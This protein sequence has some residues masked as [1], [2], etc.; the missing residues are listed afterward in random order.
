MQQVQLR[1]KRRRRAVSGKSSTTLLLELVEAR[2][3][4]IA[5][6][7]ALPCAK[8]LPKAIKEAVLCSLLC[9][10]APQ[11][12]Y[13]ARVRMCE[14]AGCAWRRTQGTHM[15]TRLCHLCCPV[16]ASPSMRCLLTPTL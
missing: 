14:H 13:V 10:T 11:F 5:E 6:I 16:H 1:G 8:D 12:Y 2:P 7:M 3:T 9:V 4:G 15:S